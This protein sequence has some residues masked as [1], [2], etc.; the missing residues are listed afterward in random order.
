LARR[1]GLRFDESVLAVGVVAS[2]PIY[3]F[4]VTTGYIDIA[5]AA[6]AASLLAVMPFG[7]RCEQK[8]IGMRLLLA[9][10]FLGL[11]AQIKFPIVTTLL[12]GAGFLHAL[13]ILRFQPARFIREHI[14]LMLC[15]GVFATFTF[16]G[17]FKNLYFHNNPLYPLSVLVGQTEILHGIVN[18]SDFGFG[19][20]TVVGSVATLNFFER[21]YAS[22][23]D[24][25]TDWSQD[26]FGGFGVAFLVC[27]VFF[28]VSLASFL[29][30]RRFS[31]KS[32]LLLITLMLFLVPGMFL[33]RYGLPL[34]V[35]MIIGALMIIQQMEE[36]VA[37]GFK[38]L[39]V[40][41]VFFGFFQLVQQ[42]RITLDWLSTQGGGRLSWQNRSAFVYEQ[43]SPDGGYTAWLRAPAVKF[44]HEHSGPGELV[45]WTTDSAPALLWNRS[46]SN[47][48][49]FL[50]AS[51]KQER[52]P[53]PGRDREAGIQL[54]SKERD[55]WLEK[56]L[57]LQPNH[58][59]V[60][61]N[62]PYPDMILAT[63]LYAVVYADQLSEKKDFL[64]LFILE[65]K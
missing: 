20:H 52:Y 49:L 60:L 38:R 5:Y 23:V 4:L 10:V 18:S 46:Y 28:F 29:P 7:R 12:F 65:K 53:F 56:I 58:I 2:F 47:K 36:Q 41:L 17:Y 51:K 57:V 39:L 44:L 33:P 42:V 37:L 15:L 6:Q 8:E 32:F 54:S 19:A 61:Q 1:I 26:S 16:F 22:W 14:F 27:G 50:P 24:I 35:F 48:L 34:A 64:P 62:S 30:R 25:F 45:V 55:R 13:F 3:Y 21:F 40:I 11:S 63:G 59:V 43:V 9:F 31:K